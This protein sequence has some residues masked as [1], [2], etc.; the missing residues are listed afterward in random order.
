M[1]DLRARFAA[2][3]RVARQSAGMTQEDLAEATGTSVDFLSKLERG[4][5]SPSLET[6]AAV[7][8]ALSLDP[9]RILQAELGDRRVTADRLALETRAAHLVRDLDDRALQALL[10]IMQTLNRLRDKP[11]GGSKSPRRK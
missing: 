4:L 2:E 1:S 10:E 5:N 9:A 6:L 7:V 11:T 8:K 3:L